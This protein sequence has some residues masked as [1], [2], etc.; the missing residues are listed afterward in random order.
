MACVDAGVDPTAIPLALEELSFNKL[1]YESEFAAIPDPPQVRITWNGIA[2]LWAFGQGSAR[3]ARAMFEAQRAADPRDPPPK[4]PI[5]GE[6]ETGVDLFELSIRLA[7]HPFDRWVDWAPKP[8]ALAKSNPDAEGNQLFLGA[9]R[10]IMRHELAHHVLKHHA[11]RSV[12]P[13][14]NK[15]QELEADDLATLWMKGN[16]AA[17]PTRPFGVRPSS[18]EL[19][20]ER[21]ALVMFVGMIW[22][23]Q[24]ELGPHGESTTHPDGASRLYAV[25][26]RIALS[27][28]SFA[29]EILS[30]I[31]KVLIDPEGHWPADKKQ[32][33]AVD[34]A[35]DALI[36]LNRRI[37][38]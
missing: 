32:A 11:R 30:Y 6:L 29:Y 20:L 18:D 27:K 8:D 33:Y 25:A 5:E 4:L 12:I 2:S 13:D 14:D 9:L 16:H 34:A 23:V 24:F 38:A 31:V 15:M 19:E 26:D 17:D 35:M 10:W 28:D 36:K 37:S 21:R 22:V 3:I 1:T 7:R